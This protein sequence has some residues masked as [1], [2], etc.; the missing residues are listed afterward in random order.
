MDFVGLMIE[1]KENFHVGNSFILFPSYVNFNLS[2]LVMTNEMD[3][4]LNG[5]NHVHN[6]RCYEPA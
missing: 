1:K 4:V 2:Q 6:T 5:R 3:R